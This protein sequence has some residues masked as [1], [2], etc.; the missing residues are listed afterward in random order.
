M[1]TLPRIL[2]P[3]SKLD[4]VHPCLSLHSHTSGCI[5]LSNANGGFVY[6]NDQSIGSV[7]TLTCNPGYMV[8]GTNPVTCQATGWTGMPT[9]EGKSIQATK[10]SKLTWP[11]HHV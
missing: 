6:T 7:A 3:L 8:N 2:F 9:C 1:Y 4:V 10:N 5:V 11:M